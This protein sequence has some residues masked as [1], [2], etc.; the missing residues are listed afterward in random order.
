MLYV[1]EFND[2]LSLMMGLDSGIIN[3]LIFPNYL[4]FLMLLS[5][6]EYA[7]AKDSYQ[8]TNVIDHPFQVGLV[9]ARNSNNLSIYDQALLSCFRAVASGLEKQVKSMRG[10][11]YGG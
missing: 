2:G 4:D 5:S 7:S 10:D 3:R 8:L 11:Y 1:Q 6:P 9:F